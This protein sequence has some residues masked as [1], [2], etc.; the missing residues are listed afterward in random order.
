MLDI[1]T[2]AHGRGLRYTARR[3]LVE[4]VLRRAYAS[5]WPARLWERVPGAAGV[6]VVHRR[7]PLR[8]PRPGAPPLRVAFASDLHL[9]PTT[10]ARTLD[11]AFSLIAGAAPDVLILGGDYVFLDA[12]PALARDLEAR[13][14][15]VPA[16]CKLAVLGN[17]DLWTHHNLLEA[18]LERA[19]ATVLVNASVRLPPPHDD[20]AVVGLDDPWTGRPDGD[21]AFA[22]A[23]GAALTIAA[24]HAPDGLSHARGRGV[25][26]YLSGHTHGGQV[27]LP[28]GYPM[29]IPGGPWSHRFPHGVHELDGAVVFVSRGVGGVE[30]P[31]RAF[32]PPDVGIFDLG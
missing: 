14:R 7:V 32:A 11:A 17:H 21:L 30:I 20:V 27:A 2:T 1:R 3:G 6:R 29:I 18:A 13:V 24:C 19:G 10:P 4:S 5:A 22:G 15:A 9:G 12:T 28:G 16:R 31:I 8:A 26:L 25:A 23:A